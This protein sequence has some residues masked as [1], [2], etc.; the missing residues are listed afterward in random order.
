MP[1]WSNDTSLETADLEMVVRRCAHDRSAGRL[2]STSQAV[3]ELRML[4]GDFTTTDEDLANAL[5]AVAVT[6]GCSVV[7]DEQAGADILRMD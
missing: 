3:E 6:L 1:A 2:V 4:T 7:F 5:T